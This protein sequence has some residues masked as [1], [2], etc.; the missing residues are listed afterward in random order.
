MIFSRTVPVQVDTQEMVTIAQVLLLHAFIINVRELLWNPANF[1]VASFCL[2]ISAFL[3]C[4][5]HALEYR[6]FIHTKSTLYPYDTHTKPI[7]Y[8]NIIHNLINLYTVENIPWPYQTYE[9]N[10]HLCLQTLMNVRALKQMSVTQVPFVQTQQDPTFVGAWKDIWVM[11]ETVGVNNSCRWSLLL[12]SG[13]LILLYSF[14]RHGEV[15]L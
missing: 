6:Y 3:A 9:A 5:K 11:A 10:I 1:F 2:L 15:F 7:P 8:H 14:R 13:S 12:T 4:T